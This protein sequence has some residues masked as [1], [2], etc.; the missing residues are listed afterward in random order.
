MIDDRLIFLEV[1][2]KRGEYGEKD[3][4]IFKNILK[5][6]NLMSLVDVYKMGIYI[7]V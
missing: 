4:V 5:C 1:D 3:V 2:K 6:I 7:H